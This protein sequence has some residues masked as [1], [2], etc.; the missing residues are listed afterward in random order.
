MLYLSGAFDTIYHQILL[1]HLDKYFGITGITLNC[2][3]SYLTERYHQVKL[4]G[5]FS[6]KISV[7]FGVPWGSVLGFLLDLFTIYMTLLS[8]I[9]Q[10]HQTVH[11]L[12]TDD[13]QLYT[14]FSTN[15]SSSAVLYIPKCFDSVQNWM[16]WDNLKLNAR[17]TQFLLIGQEVSCRL[18]FVWYCRY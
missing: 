6:P 7:Q 3:A 2:I 18:S 13:S 8:I 5:S 15:D 1:Y 10:R 4:G 12:Y 17:K 14:S 11:H 9:I 16:P